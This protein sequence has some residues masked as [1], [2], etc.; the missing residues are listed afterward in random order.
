MKAHIP[1]INVF[2]IVTATTLSVTTLPKPAQRRAISLA[3]RASW[4]RHNDRSGATWLLC[5]ARIA[6]LTGCPRWAASLR[7]RHTTRRLP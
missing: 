2:G 1:Y 3:K 7:H 5:L 4:L 6:T